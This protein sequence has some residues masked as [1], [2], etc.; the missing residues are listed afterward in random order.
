MRVGRVL[1][2]R[3][4][5]V[6]MMTNINYIY[7]NHFAIYV[8]IELCCMFESSIVL[9]YIVVQSPTDV[10]FV[11]A[12]WTAAHQAS[13]SLTISR[14]LPGVHSDSHPSSQWCHP[15]ISPSDSLFSFC[16]QSFPTSGTFPMSWLFTSDDRIPGVSASVSVLPMSIQG[17]FPNLRLTGLI[18]LLSKELSGVFSSTTVSR[19]RFFGILP[20]LW[21]NSHNHA[22]PLGRPEPWLYRALWQNNLS[23]FQHTV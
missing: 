21:S 8:N 20:S 15:A 10:W 11:V 19:Y 6:T 23:V 9:L 4:K 5:N 22:W 17:W 14:S 2:T 18:S 16:P 1:V 3:N 12:P 13:L 7:W